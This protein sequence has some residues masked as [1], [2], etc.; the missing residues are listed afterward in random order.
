M[1]DWIDNDELV[2]RTL[3]IDAAERRVQHIFIYCGRYAT[4][5]TDRLREAM[6]QGGE[7]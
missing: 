2:R 7:G 4:L 1:P 5:E 3:I 6:G